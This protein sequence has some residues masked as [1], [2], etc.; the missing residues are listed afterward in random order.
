MKVTAVDIY[1]LTKATGK[2]KL[3][4]EEDT[5]YTVASS[6]HVEMHDSSD[7]TENV[8]EENALAIGNYI[9][10]M[11]TESYAAKHCDINKVYKKKEK[12]NLDLYSMWNVMQIWCRVQTIL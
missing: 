12:T 9:L 5:A 11:K 6:S 8:L 2:T 10:A 1:H 4:E 3:I 7:L